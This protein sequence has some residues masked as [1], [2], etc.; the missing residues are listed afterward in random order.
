MA[1]V[2]LGYD[3][4]AGVAAALASIGRT[5]DVAFSPD[6]ARLAVAALLENRVLVVDIDAAAGAGPVRLSNA[7]EIESTSLS[8]PHGLSWIDDQTLIVAN[9]EGAVVIFETAAAD[10][11]SGRIALEP[12]R[13]I[14][15]AGGEPVVTP[16]S[17]SILDLGGDLFELLVCNNYVHT[18]SRHLID[19][20]EGFAVKASDILLR[21][22]LDVP[23]GVAHSPAGRWVAISDHFRH[24]V[25][26]YRNTP[27]LS[28]DTP[29]C[30]VLTGLQYAH[31]LRFT[32]DESALLVADSGAPFVHLY[33]A[34]DGDWTGRRA[35][36]STVRVM[37]DELFESSRDNQEEGGPKGIALSPDGRLLV[38]TCTQLPLAFLDFAQIGGAPAAEPLDGADDA[39]RSR[40][41]MLR[42]AAAARRALADATAEHRRAREDVERVLASRSWRITAPLRRIGAAARR[43]RG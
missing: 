2:R 36:A 3:A 19:R 12:V 33:R 28:A 11:K 10:G 32:S 7:V 41:A 27:G 18:V 16:G 29:P 38:L 23:D 31:G 17:L 1:T 37:T 9:R 25:N 40:E 14:G 4:D 26:L 20:R 43:R 21:S 5:E 39:E 24:C 30:G 22:G 6:G 34:A 13:T 42:F 15:G 35:P 8:R